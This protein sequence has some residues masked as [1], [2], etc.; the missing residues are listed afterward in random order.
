MQYR[1]SLSRLRDQRSELC[2]GPLDLSELE[3][4]NNSQQY[5]CLEN[6]MSCGGDQ[7]KRRTLQT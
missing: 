5:Y 6:L 1:Q 2:Q 7:T 3:T 4:M